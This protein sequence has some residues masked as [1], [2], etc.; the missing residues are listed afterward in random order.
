MTKYNEAQ[1]EFREK[2]KGRI[3]RQLEISEWQT[4]TQTFFRVGLKN[5]V[6]YHN[7]IYMFTANVE[8]CLTA[9]KA[10]T[11]EELEEM[12]DGGNAAVFTAGVGTIIEYISMCDVLLYEYNLSVICMG[13]KIFYLDCCSLVWSQ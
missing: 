10:T 8:S 6:S 4:H 5:K 1:V 12:L 7:V 2:S 3:Q 11:D 9:G 13:C